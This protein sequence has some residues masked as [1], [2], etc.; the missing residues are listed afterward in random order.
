MLDTLAQVV[1][2]LTLLLG[3]AS[4]AIRT[5]VESV[6]GT[7][8][9]PVVGLYVLAIAAMS[10]VLHLPFA[11]YHGVVLERR[12]GLSTERTARWLVDHLKAV[13]I[14]LGCLMVGGEVVALLLRSSPSYWW[15]LSALG[16]SA[17]LV[18]I[19]HWAPVWLLPL[20]YDVRPLE[21][22]TL[23]ARLIALAERAGTPVLGVFEWRVGD[24]TTKAN[25]ALVGL[26]RTRR[27]L[28]SDT[29]L[30]AHSDE[31]IETVFAHELAHH[32]YGDIWSALAL[33][34]LLVTAGLYIADLVLGSLA[35]WLG[36]GGKA[37]VAGLP[38]LVL[39]VG[40]VSI[41]LTPVANM[42]SRAHERRADRY[43]LE[44]TK[45]SAAFISAMKRLAAT[46]LAEERPSRFVQ[47]LLHTHPSTA[48]RIEA[49]RTW[50]LGSRLPALGPKMEPSG[51]EPKA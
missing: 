33:D 48:A 42:L 36:L 3:G 49:A 9:I 30:A 16:F 44:T 39:T 35:V 45:N 26:G 15:L 29:L 11:F 12:Y 41:A 50:A 24:R 2:L 19:A 27:I 51:R 18:L 4:I 25:A 6:V 46:N 28:V 20:F 5:N 40:A 37:D 21:R 1:F 31:E 34:A 43:A 8:L 47:L 13:V 38:L 14:V 23:R 17:A 22:P 10:E 7:G 32:V